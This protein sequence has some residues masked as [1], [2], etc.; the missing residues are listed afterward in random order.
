MRVKSTAS[1]ICSGLPTYPGAKTA[2]K[3]GVAARA[4]TNSPS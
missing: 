2:T 1:A 4:T 3:Y